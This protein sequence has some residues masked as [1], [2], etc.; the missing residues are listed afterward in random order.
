[1]QELV[2]QGLEKKFYE[3]GKDKR[4]L[5]SFLTLVNDQED[6]NGKIWPG[7]KKRDLGI[8]YTVTIG[9]NIPSE[10]WLTYH[11]NKVDQKIIKRLFQEKTRVQFYK[12]LHDFD[13][14]IT[15][16]YPNSILLEYYENLDKATH[17]LENSTKRTIEHTL[18]NLIVKDNN[19]T[20][21][22]ESIIDGAREFCNKGHQK[23]D[24]EYDFIHGFLYRRT[25]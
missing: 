15:P 19:Y 12:L 8:L 18:K 23:V 1:M 24:R 7:L 11:P 14:D 25:Q 6:L 10:D 4:L 20:L 13:P 17:N 16:D 3:T 5:N 21:I 9:C 22:G 2:Y